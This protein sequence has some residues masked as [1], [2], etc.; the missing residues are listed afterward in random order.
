MKNKN[1][2]S[3]P[4]N[5]PIILALDVDTRDQALQIADD[6]ADIVGGIKLGPRL[7]LRYGMDFVKEIASRAPVFLDN[8]HFDIPST[9]EAAVRAS[10]EAGASLVTVHAMSGREALQ[11]MAEVE[12]ELSQK[13]PFKVLAVTIL[14]SWD[15]NSLPQNMKEQP[16]ATHVTDLVGLVQSSGLSSVVCSPHELDLLQNRDLYLVTPGIR[17]SMQD[18]GDQKR[19]MGPKEALRKGASALVVGRPILEAKNIKEA[20]T[21]FV[22]AV[23]EEK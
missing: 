11:R 9:M 6:V 4:M 5:N 7:C 3:H 19:I 10:F 23:Y 15:Q 18:S 14:T 21:D 13:R 22:M 20:A 16:I 1:L 2:R 12:K 17:F 8:K